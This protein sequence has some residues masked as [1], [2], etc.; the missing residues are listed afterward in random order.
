M[1]VWVTAINEDCKYIVTSNTKRFPQ[2]IGNIDVK[3]PGEFFDMM[4]E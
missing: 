4:M 3:K 2:K 1:H